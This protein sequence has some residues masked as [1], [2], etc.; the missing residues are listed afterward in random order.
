MSFKGTWRLFRSLINPSQTRGKTQK[1]LRRAL[2]GYQFTT[3]QLADTLGDRYLCRTEDPSGSEYTYSG[4]LNQQ[5]DAPFELHDLKVALAKMRRGTAPGR[6]RMT[7]E[8]LANLPGS[9]YLHFEEALKHSAAT[10]GSAAGV[11]PRRDDAAQLPASEQLAEAACSTADLR[12]EGSLS[13]EY[14]DVDD[15]TGLSL[16]HSVSSDTSWSQSS[17]ASSTSGC[18]AGGDGSRGLG[19]RNSGFDGCRG[20]ATAPTTICVILD[21]LRAACSPSPARSSDDFLSVKVAIWD[22]TRPMFSCDGE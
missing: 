7:V 10:A 11:D 5:L 17:Y 21:S 22:L 8:L 20:F 16:I 1:Q 4:K 18:G 12:L 19:S 9:G 3:A 2:Q 15:S 13:N 14:H 6:D